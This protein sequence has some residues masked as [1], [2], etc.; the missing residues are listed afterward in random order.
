MK[1][2]FL[3]RVLCISKYVPTRL[4]YAAAGTNVFIQNIKKTYNL[5][6]SATP[7]GITR[8]A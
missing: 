3:K 2:I 8:E 6:G 7:E 5:P 4:I 1:A